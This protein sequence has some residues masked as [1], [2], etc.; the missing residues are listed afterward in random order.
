MHLCDHIEQKSHGF[1]PA[2]LNDIRPNV[3][4]RSMNPETTDTARA[5]PRRSTLSQLF[6]MYFFFGRL[7]YNV[8][9]HGTPYGVFYTVGMIGYVMGSICQ[10]PKRH[11][12]VK[13]S[14]DPFLCMYYYFLCYNMHSL[15]L[16]K[17]IRRLF[18]RI[19][20]NRPDDHL[21]HRVCT[22]SW[23]CVPPVLLAL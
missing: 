18:R 14:L 12:W 9:V 7:V 15:F 19:L 11:I 13:I 8:H 21:V 20:L 2:S 6:Y 5:S 3:R 22:L 16:G 4:S 23:T 1:F 10:I 17:K